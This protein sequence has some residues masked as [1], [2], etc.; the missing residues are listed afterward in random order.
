M[1]Q[2]LFCIVIIFAACNDHEQH[3]QTTSDKNSVKVHTDTTI[4]LKE[5]KSEDPPPPP[6]AAPKIYANARFKDVVV[7]QTGDHKFLIKGKAQVFEANISWV[8]EDG[9]EELKK[10]FQMT[11]AGAPAW[12]NFTFSIDV[13]KKR[14]N[15]TLTLILFESSAKDGS[16]QHELPI[17]LY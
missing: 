7:E 10:G 9:H 6:P 2:I 3:S 1:K 11:D 13:Q 12:G 16:R 14:Q 4:T 15:S 17:S 8:V 5:I